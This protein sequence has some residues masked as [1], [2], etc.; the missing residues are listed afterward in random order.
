MEDG[1]KYR[2]LDP[3]ALASQRK[4]AWPLTGVLAL[5]TVLITGG[6]ASLPPETAQSESQWTGWLVCACF[7]IA[8]PT[9]LFLL[10]RERAEHALLQDTVWTEGDRLFVQRGTFVQSFPSTPV[11]TQAP[12]QNQNRH[13][14]LSGFEEFRNE[15]GTYRLDRRFLWP[16]G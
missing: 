9:P 13:M 8:T 1:V 15:N 4:V 7:A 2:Y 6:V 12:K 16:V 10:K 11:R 3:K 5:M 14:F